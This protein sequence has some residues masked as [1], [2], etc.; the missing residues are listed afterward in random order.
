MSGSINESLKIQNGNFMSLTIL[1]DRNGEVRSLLARYQ[2]QRHRDL[3]RL[4][5]Q[6]V[7]RHEVEEHRWHHPKKTP[8]YGYKLCQF[9]SH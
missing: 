1:L 5:G 8:H 6:E 9:Y 2:L 7:D 3:W 4:R